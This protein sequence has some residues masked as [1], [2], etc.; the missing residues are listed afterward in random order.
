VLVENGA[1][2]NVR[3]N[4]GNTPLMCAINNKFAGIIN[5]LIARNTDL[6]VANKHNKTA[7]DLARE[8]N[9]MRVVTDLKFRLAEQQR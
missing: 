3:D 1:D 2:I 5:Y 8:K 9:L 4:E 7:M 6:K